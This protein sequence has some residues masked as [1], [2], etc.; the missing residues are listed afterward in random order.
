MATYALQWEAIQLSIVKGCTAY[1]MFGTSPR[2]DPT[3]PMYGLYKFK[4]GFGGKL[5]QSLRCWDYPLLPKQYEMF[6]AVESQAVGF[7]M[8]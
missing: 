5:C 1:D 2:P 6:K 3:H 4:S 7:H 8:R